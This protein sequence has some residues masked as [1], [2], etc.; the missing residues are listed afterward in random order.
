MKKKKTNGDRVG[1]LFMQSQTYFGSDSMIHSLIMS[2]LDRSRFEVH[3][4]V[5]RGTKWDPSASLPAL[6]KVPGVHIRPTSFG[7]SINFRSWKQKLRDTVFNGPRSVISLIG[8]AIYARRHRIK[9]I[10][11]TEKPRDAFYGYLL[12]KAAG[13]R[14]I[15]H[16]HVGVNH[17]WMLSLTQYAM[18]HATG[19]LGVSE[20]VQST[21][22]SSGYEP[23][24]VHYVVNAIDATKWDPSISGDDV[25]AEFGISEGTK[26]ISIISRVYPWKGHRELLKALAKVS[27]EFDDYRLLLVG[28]DDIRATPG[29]GSFIAELREMV[30]ELGLQDHV[31]FTGFRTDIVK[32]LAATDIYAMPSYEEPCAV[33]Y[34]EAM[35][36][37]TPVIAYRSPGGGGTS[38][39]VDDGKA[40][41]L[42]DAYDIDQ[43][44]A[45]LLRLLRNDDERV[46]MGTYARQRVEEYYTPQRIA[47][48]AAVV[49][50]KVLSAP[51]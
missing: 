28:E 46:A 50:D 17:D 29:H 11:G 14:S 4:A 36:M 16:L 21:A 25:R 33:A 23:E 41:L 13:A 51:R 26:V 39:L 27:P 9:I 34:L 22:I 10:H 1:V 5:N 47:A 44:A 12:A 19:L 38:Q 18:R 42:S 40:G 30:A 43:L 7:T 2:E 45:N 35:A 24:R 8:L 32:L 48:D 20:Y 6:R 31:I 3:A 37:A 49:Y 15:V